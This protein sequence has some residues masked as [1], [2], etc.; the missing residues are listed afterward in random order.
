M[1]CKIQTMPKYSPASLELDDLRQQSAAS[2][3]PGWPVQSHAQWIPKSL[4]PQKKHLIKE[5]ELR[6]LQATFRNSQEYID[7]LAIN[8]RPL[9]ENSTNDQ[10]ER[11]LSVVSFNKDGMTTMKNIAAMPSFSIS[12]FCLRSSCFRRYCRSSH[13]FARRGE[14][15]GRL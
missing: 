11:T 8:D 10:A 3:R 9:E 6:G 15:R 2:I 7:W 12:A 1:C 4:K 13:H 5:A 14:W